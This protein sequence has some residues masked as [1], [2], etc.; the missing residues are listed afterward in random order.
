MNNDE[1]KRAVCGIA[2]LIEL[3]SERKPDLLTLRKMAHAIVH[4]GPN[5]EGFFV[6]PRVGLAHRRLSIVGLAD[7]QQPMFNED[8]SV[9][10]VFNGEIFD[11]PELRDELRAKGHIFRTHSDT[12]CLVHLWEEMGE[13]MF[14]RL[15][16]Q[17]AFCIYDR[18]EQTI[19]LARDRI[20]ICPLHWARRGDTFYFGSEI[21][22]ILASGEVEAKPDIKGVDHIFTYL[23]MATRR[24]MFEGISSLL[25]GT[26]LKIKLRPHG[27]SADITERMYFDV[28]FP[29]QG[30]EYNPPEKKA[31]EEF[32]ELFTK[33]VNIRLRAD[34][35]V[36][37]YLS[38]GVDS[39][40]VAATISKIRGESVPTFTIQIAHEGFDETDRALLAAKTI[41]AKPTIV[42]LR[43]EDLAVAYPELV[44]ASDCAVVDT[45]SAALL[46][47][48]KEVHRQ[49]FRVTITGEG[50]DEALA[51]YPWFK[52]TRLLRMLDVG[53]LP[54]SAGVR[55]LFFNAIG[56]K[57]P[58]SRV[59]KTWDL[60]GG[61]H[62]FNDLYGFIAMS[63]SFFYKPE[64]WAALDGHIA[65]EDM[66]INRERAKKWHPL[67]R[68][69]Y[70]G[71]KTMLPGLL[72]NHKGDRPAMNSSVEGRFPFL[73]EDVQRY[74]TRIHPR[75]KLRG[76]WRDK[77]LLR[78][79]A[80][81]LLPSEIANR[82][83]AIFRAPF[84]T[85]FF[86]NPPEYIKQ[87]LTRESMERTGLFDVDQVL[88][89]HQNFRKLRMAKKLSMEMGLTAVMSTQLWH[90]LYL[91]G[92]LCDLPTWTPPPV[93]ESKPAVVRKPMAEAGSAVAS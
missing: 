40:A 75:F 8:G 42:T 82:P 46:C 49:G 47:L 26:Y 63:R 53:G 43:G 32:A 87:L 60:I 48:A 17:F 10:V 57:V 52:A 1:R 84:A 18:K 93:D 61:R 35:P 77:H 3:S 65:Y 38:G 67:N 79:F 74:C 83:K 85:T 11:Y 88:F 80:S 81:D 70:L 12:E 89:Q 56:G 6:E 78:I 44:R 41:G 73:D 66:A 21:K 20:G 16:G 76:I 4:R 25:P 27:Q 64:T 36:V 91:G 86:D 24:T 62:A 34:V 59:Q 19:I 54:V 68:A 2:G 13:K 55:R 51:G 37:A 9:V 71:Y 69:L 14:D 58:W 31:K 72:M 15:R 50:A 33:A 5:E 23:A 90:H 28:D 29:D 22:A 39:T 92:G 30:D 45:S 7:G